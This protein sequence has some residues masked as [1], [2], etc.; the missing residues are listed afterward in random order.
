MATPQTLH[1]IIERV[2]YL[3]TFLGLNKSRFSGEIGLKPQTYNNF[4]G[5]QGSKPSIELVMGVVQRFGVNPTWVLTGG[6]GMFQDEVSEKR[7]LETLRGGSYDSVVAD[8]YQRE[9][10]S[11]RREDVM[12]NLL[13]K[14]ETF[15][16]TLRQMDQRLQQMGNP[17]DTKR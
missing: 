16:E 10:D 12:E 2:E 15:E 1:D 11:K 9:K 6:G 8:S 13:K 17:Q 3:R 5:A 14:M 7:A 4:I